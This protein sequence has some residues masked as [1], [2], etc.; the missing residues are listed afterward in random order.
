MDRSYEEKRQGIEEGYWLFKARREFIYNLTVRTGV[1]HDSKI[2]DIGC[3]GGYLI[4]YFRDKGFIN[5]FGLDV[6]RRSVKICRQRGLENV[7]EG[8]GEKLP[9]PDGCFDDILAVDVLEHI[10]DDNVALKEWRRVLK[11]GGRIFLTV[12]AFPFLWSRH[13]EICHHFRRY[14][15]SAILKILKKSGFVVEKT[16]FWNFLLF[17][18]AGLLRLSRFFSRGQGN[19]KG[20][21]LYRV[22]SIINTILLSLLRSENSLG[23][24]ICYPVGLSLFA[25]VRKSD[26]VRS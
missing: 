16:G 6:S 14:S 5:L 7:W 22:N 17:F 3:G 21:Q 11:D 8:V 20:D 26:M 2:L 12:P 4:D 9:L 1:P 24:L 13:D 25:V 10:A 23:R 19:Q 18:P 15:K